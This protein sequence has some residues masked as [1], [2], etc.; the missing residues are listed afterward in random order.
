[1]KRQTPRQSASPPAGSMCRELDKEDIKAVRTF[2]PGKLLSRTAALLALAVLVLG[3]AGMVDQGLKWL[4][5]VDLSSTPWLNYGLLF[6]LPLL[7][8][9]SELIVEWRAERGLGERR[10]AAG[11]DFRCCFRFTGGA[12][13]C[14]YWIL[15]T[16]VIRARTPYRTTRPLWFERKLFV[17]LPNITIDCRSGLVDRFTVAVCQ[18][19][20]CHAAEYA[21]DHVQK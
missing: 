7:T 13:L 14:S 20:L 10:A 4:L 3:F 19:S 9:G 2:L 6:G 15:R 11:F 1:M 21:F 5:N 16:E 8:V 18:N 17:S 12:D